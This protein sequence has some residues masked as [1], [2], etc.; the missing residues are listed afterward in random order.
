MK[1]MMILLVL[2]IYSL[3]LVA[4]SQEHQ[5]TY[6]DYL[7]YESGHYRPYTCGCPQP[8]I[9][10]GHVDAVTNGICDICGYTITIGGAFEFEY[11]ATE[12]GHCPHK[13]GEVCD[14]TCDKSPHEDLNHDMLCDICDYKNESQ[15]PTNYFLRNQ[16]GCEWLNEINVDDITEIK[17]INEAVGVVPG[18]PKS[19]QSST[20]NTVIERIFEDYYWLDS[21]PIP[22]ED[23]QIDGGGAVTIKF[24]LKDGTEKVIY[25]NNGNYCDSN[26]NYFDLHYIPNFKDTDNSTKFYGFVTYIGSATIYG[27]DNN[28]I[29]Q[30][31]VD[32]I[33]YVITGYDYSLFDN[34]YD[35]YINTE[36][37]KLYFVKIDIY[38]SEGNED[39]YVRTDY[40]FMAEHDKEFCY[41]IVGKNVDELIYQY[42]ENNN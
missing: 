29:C 9:L 36:F 17:I 33:E 40:Y 11:V 10:E 3:G 21:W 16:L 41:R 25:I 5:H 38:A 34:G 42:S 28:P 4:C 30:F 39:E 27:S 26:N 8:E 24:I 31:P 12:E 18:T 13:V 15:V 23:G 37:G 19:I 20:D 6:G 32:E 7:A 2:F 1:K 35:Y 22:K 14:G